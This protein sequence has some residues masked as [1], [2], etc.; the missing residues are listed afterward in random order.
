VRVERVRLL[1]VLIRASSRSSTTN[2]TS[3]YPSTFDLEVEKRLVG[4]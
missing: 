2:C 4:V 3:T 1:K